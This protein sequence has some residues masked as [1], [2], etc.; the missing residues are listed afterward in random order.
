MWQFVSSLRRVPRM[1]AYLQISQVNTKPFVS[2]HNGNRPRYLSTE[3]EH[4]T[5]G[6]FV[7]FTSPVFDCGPEN[8]MSFLSII[9]TFKFLK[10]KTNLIF[11]T[12]FVFIYQLP[13]QAALCPLPIEIRT[14]ISEV[15][16]SS[17]SS[18]I[19]IFLLTE[20]YL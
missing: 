2:A 17:C 5:I 13:W 10:K 1:P 15:M 3:S 18:I 20:V 19:L 6:A 8:E 12:Y 14:H 4:N 9:S 16:S 7:R 11:N